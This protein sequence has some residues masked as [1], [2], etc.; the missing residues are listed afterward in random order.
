MHSSVNGTKGKLT[1]IKS[2]ALSH[3]V[4]DGL[5]GNMSFEHWQDGVRC[6]TIGSWN[7]HTYLPYGMDFFVILSSASGVAGLRGQANYDAGN[8]FEDAMARYRVALGEKAVSLDLGA[9][10]E[11]GVLAENQ[12]L[13]NRVLAYGTL[14]PITRS[15]LHGILD[16]F[17]NPALPLLTPDESQVV[18]GL[19]QGGG[20]GLDALDFGRQ[21]MLHPL[22]KKYHNQETSGTADDEE[23]VNF[24]ERLS[25]AASLVDGSEV[26]V[27]ALIKKLSKTLSTLQDGEIDVH[28]PLQSYGVDS[29]LAV[30]L[31]NWIAREFQ[32]DV[33]VFE[34]Q[35]GSTFS[36]L[37]M[38]VAARSAIKHPAWAM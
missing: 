4:Q 24:R 25:T 20:D 3:N 8:T 11:D 29:L 36:T 21:P 6:K 35:G 12:D 33:A 27:Q 10:I 23:K 34:T 17:Y 26:I 19:G 9:L 31:R 14:E 16:H 18:I 22:I 7:L 32:A 37:G 5:F 15:N 1:S 30:E 2:Q 28:Q 13:L 38:I